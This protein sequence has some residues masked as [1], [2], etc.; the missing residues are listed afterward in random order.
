MPVAVNGCAKYI[1]S[2]EG[3]GGWD[4]VWSPMALK[5]RLKRNIMMTY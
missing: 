4:L 3:S 2:A 1:G 5:D